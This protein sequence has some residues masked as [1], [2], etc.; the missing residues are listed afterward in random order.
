MINLFFFLYFHQKSQQ[1]LFDFL[2]KDETNLIPYSAEFN[3]V[4][5]SETLIENAKG[6]DA[7]PV[8][9]GWFT[10]NGFAFH[11]FVAFKTSDGIIWIEPQ[12][13]L[14]YIIVDAK[15]PLCHKDGNCVTPP[16]AFVRYDGEFK[17]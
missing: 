9:V 12:N 7:I 8:E 2:L 14:E 15:N 16:L 11:E 17:H 13:D 5:F 1:D 3:C 6:F 10:E 4:A